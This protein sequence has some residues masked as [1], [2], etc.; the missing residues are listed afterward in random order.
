MNV[1]FQDENSQ[2]LG[3]PFRRS[4]GKPSETLSARKP[5]GNITNSSLRHGQPGN[6]QKDASFQKLG[7]LPSASAR[8]K[9]ST[10]WAE[11]AKPVDTKAT[12]A[13]RSRLDILCDNPPEK[14]FGMT[15]E[16]QELSRVRAIEA[17][18]SSSWRKTVQS[19]KRPAPAAVGAKGEAVFLRLMPEMYGRPQTR[20]VLT[21]QIVA[22]HL[23]PSAWWPGSLLDEPALLPSPSCSPVRTG[24][25]Q[26]GQCVYMNELYAGRLFIPPSDTN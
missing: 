7:A 18:V 1:I 19:W 10:W 12:Q 6:A 23:Q 13:Q 14:A 17:E 20:S 2:A 22:I 8:P 24:A 4:D 21:S 11:K 16:D 3:T 26:G 15:W 25:S 9:P 5:L